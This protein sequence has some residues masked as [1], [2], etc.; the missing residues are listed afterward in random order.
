MCFYYFVCVVCVAKI[1]AP[2]LTLAIMATGESNKGLQELI[3]EINSEQHYRVIPK[4]E[5]DKLIRG[6]NERKG[7]LTPLQLQR[8]LLDFNSAGAK[9]KV[10][11]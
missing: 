1:Y 3:N 9:H 4:A 6:A 11:G 8:T 5:Y 7:P 10:V 2:E